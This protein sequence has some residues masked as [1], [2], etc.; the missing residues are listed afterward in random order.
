M[1]S[2]RQRAGGRDGQGP[3]RGRGDPAQFIA[4]MMENDHDGDGK[5]SLDEAPERMQDR[6]DMMDAN[7]D[8]FLEKAELEAMTQ[9]FNRRRPPLPPPRFMLENN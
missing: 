1:I 4:R 8:G 9:R 2:G 7:G 5:I 6:F 3:R